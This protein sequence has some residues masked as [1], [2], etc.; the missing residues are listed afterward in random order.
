MLQIPH[1]LLSPQLFL[2]KLDRKCV[3]TS[4][5]HL[6]GS[7]LK[8]KTKRFNGPCEFRFS[9]KLVMERWNKVINGNWAWT[10]QILYCFDISVTGRPPKWNIQDRFSIW[11]LWSIMNLSGKLTI[12]KNCGHLSSLLWTWK[13][14]L[15]KTESVHQRFSNKMCSLGHLFTRFMNNVGVI[16]FKRSEKCIAIIKRRVRSYIN[17]MSYYKDGKHLSP[18][19]GKAINRSTLDLYFMLSLKWKLVTFR[20]MCPWA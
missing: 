6:Q 10:Q 20:G 9:H 7:F 15:S 16:I 17:I 18:P 14:S 1:R 5:W 19:E 3:F 13:S 4:L 2:T 8:G 12:Y 11:D